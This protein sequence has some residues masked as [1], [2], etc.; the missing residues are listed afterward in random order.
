[1]SELPEG[2]EEALAAMTE[3]EV[4]DLLLRVRPGVESLDPMER[5]AAALRHERG[6]DRRGPAPSK[7]DAADAL[8][9]LR[10]H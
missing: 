8:R 2:A 3:S 5:A 4:T 1:M 6:V 10:A 7:Q 9:A